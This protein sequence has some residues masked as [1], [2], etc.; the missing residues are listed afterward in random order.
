MSLNTNGRMSEAL[1][2]NAA[3][4]SQLVPYSEKTLFC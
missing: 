4:V 3:Q 2:E 1:D